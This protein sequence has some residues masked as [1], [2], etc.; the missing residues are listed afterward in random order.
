MESYNVCGGANKKMLTMLISTL[1]VTFN[2][3][4]IIVAPIRLITDDDVC[5]TCG[6]ALE[7]AKGIE[8][9]RVFK[10]G[11]KYSEAYKLHS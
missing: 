4:D 6:G 7:H 9:G 2:V 8:V 10:L 1:N 11:T 3:E 5:P